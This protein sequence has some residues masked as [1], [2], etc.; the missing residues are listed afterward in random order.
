MSYISMA[1]PWTQ[2]LTEDLSLHQHF[3]KNSAVSLGKPFSGFILI[4]MVK[5]NARIRRWRQLFSFWF[6]TILPMLPSI[7]LS[8]PRKGGCVC[9]RSRFQS[10]VQAT[11][12]SSWLHP[13]LLSESLHILCQSTLH[14]STLLSGAPKGVGF[15]LACSYS[16]WNA[17]AGS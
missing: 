5:Q 3:A 9:I 16:G 11:L 2:F 14:S 13:P 7:T 6:H 17:E 8:C 15:Y 10:S 1:F 4:P 12:V